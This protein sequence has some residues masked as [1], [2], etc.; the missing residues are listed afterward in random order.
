VALQFLAAA[1]GESEDVG[2][3]APWQYGYGK[4]D[5]QTGRLASYTPLPHFTGTAWQGGAELPDP[6][7]GW[8]TLNAGGGHPGNDADHAAIRRWIV[9]ADGSVAI[10]GSLEHLSDQGD[11]VRGRIVS[12]RQGLL[13]EW[14]VHRRS[15]PT[16]LDGIRVKRGEK[17]DL[18]TDCVSGPGYD[19]FRWAVAIRLTSTPAND[20]RSWDSSSDFRGPPAAALGRWQRLAQVLLMTNE[21]A[22]VD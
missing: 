22:Y 19:S 16:K 13:A 15:V 14:T 18:V 9:A 2:H 7:L 11:G 1:L 3:A 21:F 8:V 12:D 17:I 5:A 20:R 6:K 10:Q 4:F